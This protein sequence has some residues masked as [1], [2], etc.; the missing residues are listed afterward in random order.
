MDGNKPTKRAKRDGECGWA[1]RHGW[2]MPKAHSRITLE[3]TD[4]RVQRL[5]EISE[6]DAKAE[7]FDE[8]TCEAVL[9]KAAGKSDPDE[10]YYV[11]D[12]S[13]D[14]VTEG[15]LCY[16]CAEAQ[17]KEHGDGARINAAT[18]P[19]SDGPAYCDKCYRPLYLS[20]TT[21]GIESELLL[22]CTEPDDIKRL[23]VKGMDA[24]IAAMIAGGIG[25]LQDEHK[26]RLAQIGFATLW[27]SINAKK[28]PWDSN[29]WVWAITFKREQA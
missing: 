27:N 9:L 16:D 3:I 1:Y 10:A 24:A 4:V 15:Y 18:C 25:D 13:E 17:Q 12:D 21:Y 28:Y 11:T 20:L 19:E 26:G 2:F 5:Q 7:G 6:E 8:E 14:D 22:G 29:P 23:P